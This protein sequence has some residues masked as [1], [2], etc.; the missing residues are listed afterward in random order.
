MPS[1][2][3]EHDA[4]CTRAISLRASSHFPAKAHSNARNP[5]IFAPGRARFV[6]TP[7]STGSGT[8][9]NT[10][11]MLRVVFCNSNVGTGPFARITSGDFRT[12]S[13]ASDLTCP[14]S[15]GPQM[16]SILMLRSSI[17][18]NS[19]RPRRTRQCRCLHQGRSRS[20]SARLRS[21]VRRS[22]CETKSGAATTR[23]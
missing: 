1:K 9:T 16:T 7:K 19:L 10:I 21:S 13:A 14:G 22:R 2:R 17:H 6:T 11:G 20:P 12:S 8:C 3:H 18:H 5:V 23:R 4:S 15:P